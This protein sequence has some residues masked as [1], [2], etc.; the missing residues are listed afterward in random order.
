MAGRFGSIVTTA[1]LPVTERPYDNP[2][3]YCILCGACQTRCPVNAIDIRRGVIDGKNQAICAPF[4]NGTRRPPHG[5]NQRKRYGCG[6][7]QVGVPCESGIP[8]RISKE[9]P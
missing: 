1:P 7:C 6:K 8:L 5:P 3:A 4:V 2:F 9:I